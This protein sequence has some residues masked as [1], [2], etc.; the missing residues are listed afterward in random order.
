MHDIWKVGELLA[1]QPH[2][3]MLLDSLVPHKCPD[4]NDTEREIWMKA[5]ARRLLDD[6]VR[7]YA[8]A[9]ERGYGV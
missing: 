1:S 5:G 7:S 4:P 6:I 9:T 8:A 2:L 3:L